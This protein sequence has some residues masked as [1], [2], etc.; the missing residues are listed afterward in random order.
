VQANSGQWWAF[1]TLN[2]P[3]IGPANFGKTSPVSATT[4]TSAVSLTWNAAS[5]AVAYR[6]CVGTLWGL[7][8]VLDQASTSAA[9]LTIT[10]PTGSYWW[11]VV[12]INDQ[13][14]ATQADG[15]QWWT[16]T[17]MPPRVFMPVVMRP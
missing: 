6:V 12:A 11:Q 10:L 9:P 8:D 15:G 1:S 16:F 7:C 14:H 2:D 13:A 3:G 5:G 17:V 4:S